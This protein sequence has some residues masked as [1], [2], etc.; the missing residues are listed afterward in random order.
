MSSPRAERIALAAIVAI[1][2]AAAIWPCEPAE[3][4]DDVALLFAQ[5]VSGETA[6]TAHDEATAIGQVFAHRSRT[7]TITPSIIRAYSAVHHGA[8]S[9]RWLHELDPAG[10][11]PEH[12]P[13]HLNWEDV[14]RPRW[15]AL[16]DH[17]RD[18][19][20]GRAQ[21]PCEVTP[22]HFGAP[23]GVDMDR[24]SRAGWRP[25]D[26]GPGVRNRFWR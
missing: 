17:A 15:L 16:L 10:N 24:A 4:E 12:W 6:M 25:V 26:C 21:S 5:T 9:R 23:H 8:P 2:I 11:R 3:A 1:I 22:R 7:G 13:S 14:W 20:A 19:V 18:V